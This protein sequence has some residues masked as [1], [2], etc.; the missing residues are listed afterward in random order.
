VWKALFC[1][2]LKRLGLDTE[3]DAR[4]S[5]DKEIVLLNREPELAIDGA[6]AGKG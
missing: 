2:A 3:P 4:R 6:T 1:C 5:R